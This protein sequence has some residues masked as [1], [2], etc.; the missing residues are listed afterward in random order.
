MLFVSTLES[1]K[2]HLGALRA[3]RDLIDRRG[4]WNVPKLV[5][6]GNRGWLND[7]VHSTL[8]SDQTLRS[9]VKLL[10]RLS[11]TELA[12]LYRNCLFSLYPSHYEGWG[13]PIT[14]SLCHGKTVLCSNAPSHLE[15]GGDFVDYF[16]VGSDASLAAAA[17][18]LI[19]NVG[20]R[21]A[22]E[23]QLQEFR[24]PSWADVSGQLVSSV[25]RLDQVL[26]GSGR[27]RDLKASSAMVIEVNRRYPFSASTLTQVSAEMSHGER[28]RVGD[29]W[30]WPDGE[31]T[32][33]S[34]SGGEMGFSL[35]GPHPALIWRIDFCGP[36]IGKFVW[37][38]RARGEAGDWS[39]G[40][41]IASG[42]QG[43]IE[44][45][46]PAASHDS[47]IV[48]V[49]GGRPV[50]DDGAPKEAVIRSIESIGI[51]GFVVLDP[52]NDVGHRAAM[53]DDI[54]ENGL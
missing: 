19:F 49:I 47:I 36:Q 40:G 11:D 2:N 3:W 1:R 54:R 37:W 8:A 20:Y 33:A 42:A 45:R 44:A 26:A 7:A 24:A 10:S 51:R 14:E 52:T 16:P 29:G 39:T 31:C 41:A 48:G 27:T 23:A 18:K 25:K 22:R 34:P 17:E 5:C 43:S 38:F 6:V 30:F 32:R 50:S 9:R 21:K 12:A 15:A 35:P 13:L 53:A 28:F 4:V 46:I